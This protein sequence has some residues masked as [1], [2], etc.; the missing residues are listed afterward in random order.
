MVSR[1]WLLLCIVPFLPAIHLHDFKEAILA[2]QHV[3][4]L[5][6]MTFNMDRGSNF[7]YLKVVNDPKTLLDNVQTTLSEIMHSHADIRARGISIEINRFRPDLVYFSEAAYVKN[8]TKNP[9][10]TVTLNAIHE[11]MTDLKNDGLTNYEIVL[12]LDSEDV[13]SP[14]PVP[15]AGYVLFR[16]REFILAKTDNPDMEIIKANTKLGIY[17]NK[18]IGHDTI[19]TQSSRYGI[20]DLMMKKQIKVKFIGTYL[21][22]IAQI[23]I[24]QGAELI[25]IL[26]QT[27]EP[28][29]LVGDLSSNANQGLKNFTTSGLHD[30]PT[31]S[32]V[33]S[34]ANL[35]DVWHFL[36]PHHGS[37]WPL[38]LEDPFIPNRLDPYERLD[39]VFVR[40]DNPTIVPKRMDLYGGRKCKAFEPANRILVSDHLFTV[41]DFDIYSI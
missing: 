2:P 33:Q 18:V 39:L 17:K 19:P 9:P 15:G 22:D 31:Y 27:A 25:E 4:S 32:N 21:S 34:Q 26:Q 35:L 38:Y 37:T 36:H 11:L 12:V 6:I 24:A 30:T 16:E 29:I 28:F 5:R 14:S 10:Q 41:T 8:D 40:R 23:Q 3:S 1:C 13:I 20:I 7:P